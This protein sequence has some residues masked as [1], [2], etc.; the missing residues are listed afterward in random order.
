[1][2]ILIAALAHLEKNNCTLKPAMHCRYVMRSDTTRI[3]RNNLIMFACGR[4]D[5]SHSGGQCFREGQYNM[6]PIGFSIKWRDC[7]AFISPSPLCML[8]VIECT[9]L[10]RALC[11]QRLMRPCP[12]LQRRRRQP[13][14]TLFMHNHGEEYLEHSLNLRCIKGWRLEWKTK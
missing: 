9:H 3:Q 7:C 1:M 4:A 13:Q 14:A 6:T 5:L 12:S 10:P 2:H 8:H 11:A